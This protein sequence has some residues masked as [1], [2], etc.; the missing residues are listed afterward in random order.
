VIASL[1]R[2]EKGRVHNDTASVFLLERT[3]SKIFRLRHYLCIIHTRFWDLLEEISSQ[4]SCDVTS[5]APVC[6]LASRLPWNAE[7]AD[8]KKNNLLLLNLGSSVST[9]ARYGL[10][11]R[12]STPATTDNFDHPVQTGYKAHLSPIHW[13]P[14]NPSQELQRSGL[15]TENSS[16]LVE[17]LPTLKQASRHEGI[18]RSGGLAPWVRNIATRW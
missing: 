1:C 14:G 11:D 7:P 13:V 17:V 2:K 18:W 16:T 10:D 15:K 12:R 8:S 4:P 3:L 6:L 9:V 5:I